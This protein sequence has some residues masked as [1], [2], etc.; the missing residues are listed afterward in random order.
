VRVASADLNGDGI[1]DIITAPG[2]GGGPLVKVFSGADLSLL[3]AFDAY[4]PGFNSGLF[5]AAGDVNGDG[6]PDIVTGPDAGGGPLVEAFSG[7]DL[8]LLVAFNAYAP[9]FLGGVHVATGNLTGTG[10]ASII[11]G[12]G[13]GGGPLV[14]IFDGNGVMQVA[15]NAYAAA[16]QNGVW[17][18]AADVNGDD[19]DEIITGPG[20]GGGPLVTVF[21]S[22]GT[23]LLGFT[24][25]PATI[26]SGIRIA[27]VPDL[28]GNGAQEIMTG[29]QVGVTTQQDTAGG[30]GGVS[31]QIYDG[32]TLALLDS[33]FAFNPFVGSYFMA[34]SS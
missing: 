27:G 34:G 19:I 30:A 20:V 6:T 31:T 13:I 10:K 5:V 9:N 3:F 26:P 15:F 16:F 33:F 4:D 8:S 29:S 12:P 28:N 22:A 2:P 17:V 24:V 1:P 7:K 11:T 18:S 32:L 21:D 14:E 25:G 23:Q